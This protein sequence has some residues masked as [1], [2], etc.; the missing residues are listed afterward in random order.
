MQLYAEVSSRLKPL[1]QAALGIGMGSCLFAISS[2]PNPLDR[3]E[4]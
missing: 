3:A 1:L 4:I 2:G